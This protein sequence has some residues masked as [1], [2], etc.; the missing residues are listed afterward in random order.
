MDIDNRW[1]YPKTMKIDH[2]DM[3]FFFAFFL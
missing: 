2:G 1:I 3:S